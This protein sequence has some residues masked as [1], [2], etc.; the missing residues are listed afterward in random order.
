MHYAIF[1]VVARS[2]ADIYGN[3]LNFV[4]YVNN[5]ENVMF[6]PTFKVFVLKYKSMKR[7]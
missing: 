2:F 7:R 1:Q 4:K 5:G 6:L 3:M